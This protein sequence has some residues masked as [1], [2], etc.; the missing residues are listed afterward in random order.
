MPQREIRGLLTSRFPNPSGFSLGPKKYARM[1]PATKPPAWP[2]HACRFVREWL[3]QDSVRMRI[4]QIAVSVACPS[5]C[6]NACTRLRDL[7]QDWP[8][9]SDA[10]SRFSDP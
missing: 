6:M 5:L 7:P 1:S 2:L 9:V 4:R 8:A 10:C 3:A